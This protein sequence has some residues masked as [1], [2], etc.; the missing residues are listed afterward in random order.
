MYSNE[1]L[2]FISIFSDLKLLT[3]EEI[4]QS[5]DEHSSFLANLFENYIS[6]TDATIH[7]ATD[8]NNHFDIIQTLLT[9]DQFSIMLDILYAKIGLN[10]SLIRHFYS[11]RYIHIDDFY[12]VFS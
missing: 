4:I 7:K 5:Y 12:C 10:V 2:V 6:E 3:K 11:F 9:T 8:Y 1:F